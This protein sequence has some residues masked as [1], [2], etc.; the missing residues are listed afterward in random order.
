[1]STDIY[2]S[3]GKALY[4][5]MEFSGTEGY[6]MTITATFGKNIPEGVAVADEEVFQTYEAYRNRQ[7]GIA[8]ND[9]NET[10][11]DIMDISQEDIA[12]K[13]ADGFYYAD[14]T[15]TYSHPENSQSWQHL[16]GG[17]VVEEF[18]REKNVYTNHETGETI[19]DVVTVVTEVDENGNE[20]TYEEQNNIYGEESLGASAEDL[21]DVYSLPLNSVQSYVSVGKING[22]DTP[23]ECIIGYASHK[24]EVDAHPELVP[25]NI[26]TKAEDIYN[27]WTLQQ[28]IDKIKGNKL[29][30]DEKYIIAYIAADQNFTISSSTMA[31]ISL[32][33]LITAS[34][35]NVDAYYDN[36]VACNGPW[37]PGFMASAYV[38]S[39]TDN[40]SDMD[41]EEKE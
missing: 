4:A 8:M 33:E 12:N 39:P 13:T 32:K 24:T 40:D 23:W 21:E 37:V 9:E 17:V 41:D 31:S 29:S 18:D 7:M 16:V 28:I 15:Y 36:I 19:E 10:A 27:R 2:V 22:V 6:N 25:E 35:L 1:M 11:F 26:R 34:G 5:V 14:G 30:E 20:Y 38:S 3:E